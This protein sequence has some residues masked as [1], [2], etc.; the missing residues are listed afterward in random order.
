MALSAGLAR[1]AARESTKFGPRGAMAVEDEEDEPPAFVRGE[2]RI[3]GGIQ[4]SCV[5]QTAVRPV[6]CRRLL[7]H[8]RGGSHPSATTVWLPEVANFAKNFPS[9]NKIT[10][11]CVGVA[12]WF[13]ASCSL[14]SAKSVVH[15]DCVLA[16]ARL[17]HSQHRA[18]WPHTRNGAAARRF[19]PSFLPVLSCLRHPPTHRSPRA[20]PRPT[21]ANERTIHDPWRAPLDRA[22]GRAPS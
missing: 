17:A 22:H 21:N 14:H 10:A 9:S 19:L 20:R 3:C 1:G 5:L 6:C 13:C 11:P 8:A 4:R 12:F 15:A 2:P 16:P 7:S 18:E